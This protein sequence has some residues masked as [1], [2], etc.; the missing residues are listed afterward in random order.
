MI[1]TYYYFKLRNGVE[2]DIKVIA[3]PVNMNL[4]LNRKLYRELTTEQREFYLANPTAK[5]QEVVRCELNPTYVPPTPDVQEY[6]AQKVKELKDACY[7]SISVTSLE[8]A[9]AI[10]KVENIT[11]DSYYSLTEAR[12]V[13]SDFRSQSKHAMTVLATYRPQIEAAQSVE[14]VDAAYEQAIDA[15]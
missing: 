11:A 14:A 8:F 5:V 9:M 1:G 15:L 3:F 12:Q 10:D 4:D 6:A 2:H 13:V 7:G